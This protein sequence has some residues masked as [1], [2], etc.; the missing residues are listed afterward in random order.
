MRLR[1]VAMQK[2]T[3]FVLDLPRHWSSWQQKLILIT[4]F[5]IAVISPDYV[6]ALLSD[7]FYS[8]PLTSAPNTFL[9]N[10]STYVRTCIVGTRQPLHGYIVCST[11]AS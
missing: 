3:R 4:S 7:E 1:R 6:L 11:D 8:V 5:K 9:F 2:T 10:L